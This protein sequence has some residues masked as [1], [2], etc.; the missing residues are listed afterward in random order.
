MC[1]KS[2]GLAVFCQTRPSCGA[3]ALTRSVVVMSTF[4]SSATLA[5]ASDVIHLLSDR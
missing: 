3:I 1:Q 2:V 5:A 4:C